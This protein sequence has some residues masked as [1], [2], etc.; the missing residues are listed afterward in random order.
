MVLFDA[1]ALVGVHKYNK[2]GYNGYGKGC[3][4]RAR[5]GEAGDVVK[6]TLILKVIPNSNYCRRLN[7]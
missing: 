5:T 6:F 1:L 4:A 2:V 7:D 3:D